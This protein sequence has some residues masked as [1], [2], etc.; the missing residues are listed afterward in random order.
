MPDAPNAKARLKI[1]IAVAWIDGE[2]QSQEREYLLKLAED[3]GLLEDSEIKPLL[4]GLRP[5]SVQNCYDWIEAYLGENPTEEV[6]NELIEAI[7]ALIYSDGDVAGEE[8]NLVSRLITFSTTD[9][10]KP[11]T[12][13]ASML[14]AVKQL[15]QRWQKTLAPR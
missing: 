11:T 4:Y 5:V 12:L 1:L 9:H 8:A 3:Q 7:S 6:A 10:S 15:Y 2:V 13:P 14:N